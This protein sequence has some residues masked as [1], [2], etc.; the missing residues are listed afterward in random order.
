[1]NIKINTLFDV[2][3]KSGV[4]PHS[5]KEYVDELLRVVDN[6]N[7]D[8]LKYEITTPEKLVDY[9][10]KDGVEVTLVGGFA[11]VDNEE[12]KRYLLDMPVEEDEDFDGEDEPVR[13]SSD[14][15]IEKFDMVIDL[16]KKILEEIE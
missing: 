11:C 2:A 15:Y 5:V 14:P 10:M 6:E 8:I 12:L 4:A 3:Y 16:L 9:L 7:I 1:M 13:D